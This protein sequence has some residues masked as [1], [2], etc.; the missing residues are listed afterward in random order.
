[1]KPKEIRIATVNE[2]K[3]R[4]IVQSIDF[5]TDLVYVWGEVYSFRNLKSR[6]FESKRFSLNEVTITRIARTVELLR[7]LFEQSKR[8]LKR[9]GY[10]V[11]GN[12]IRHNFVNREKVCAVARELN[13]DL[14]TASESDYETIVELINE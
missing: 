14:A 13:I 8:E 9:E 6:H 12:E 1:M 3:V 10:L 5:D 4:Y 7:E 11:R 2:T